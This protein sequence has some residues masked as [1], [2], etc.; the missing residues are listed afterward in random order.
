VSVA[1]HR[2]EA[3]TRIEFDHIEPVAQGGQSTVKGIRLRCRA[4]NQY[5]AE[6]VFGTDFMSR[7]REV[8]QR[9]SDEARS[10]AAAAEE[11]RALIAAAADHA[12]ALA[13]AAAEEARVRAAAAAE[14]VPWLQA[15]GL[16]VEVARR[17]AARCEAIPDA[18]LEERVR[19]ALSCFARP[20][21]ARA[22]P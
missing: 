18:P 16:R 9:A 15:L 19:Y 3:R 12:R 21:R 4:H 11:A 20:A 14:V 10:R 22:A 7:K 5:A 13:A 8:A 6:C 1:G 2:C 17:A